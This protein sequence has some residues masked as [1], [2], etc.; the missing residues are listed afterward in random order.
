MSFKDIT[1]NNYFHRKSARKYLCH[2]Q[3]SG[4]V[5]LQL[6]VMQNWMFWH[7]LKGQIVPR[8][9]LLT[10]QS[11]SGIFDLLYY[12]SNYSYLQ[13]YYKWDTMQCIHHIFDT[14]LLAFLLFFCLFFMFGFCFLCAVDFTQQMMH[15]IIS[16]EIIFGGVLSFFFFFF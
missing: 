12:S 15:K 8:D 3:G 16:V 4:S 2:P 13:Q 14:L 11:K 7:S 10:S 9:I 6:E 1:T 5:Y